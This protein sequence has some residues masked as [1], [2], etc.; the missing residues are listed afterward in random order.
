MTGFDAL[1]DQRG[2]L[3]VYPEAQGFGWGNGDVAYVNVLLSQVEAALPVD[4]ARVFAAGFSEGGFFAE[5]LACQLPGEPLAALVAVGATI[6]QVQSRA[7]APA[8]PVSVLL[9]DGT[10]DQN[11][12]F[13]GG[14][15][16]GYTLLSAEATA[17]TW[18]SIDACASPATVSASTAATP[19]QTSTYSG[20]AH[21]TTV[22]LDAIQGGTHVW[23]GSDAAATGSSGI[24]ATSLAWS[25]FAAHPRQ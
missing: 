4:R 20:C 15:E 7:C 11:I 6:A 10:A 17:A 19:V 16:F 18:V 5:Q 14:T 13:D 2:F 23:P 21:G 8:H 1:A 22:V 25:F 3:V 24:D 9:L 12:P